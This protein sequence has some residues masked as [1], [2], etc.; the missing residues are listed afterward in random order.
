MSWQIQ[1]GVNI[2][3]TNSLWTVANFYYVIACTNFSLL[4]HAKVES[5]PVMCYQKRR[6]TRFIHPDADAVARHP[7]LRYFKFSTTD[8]VSIAN[9]DFVIGKSIDGEVFSE[10]AEHKIVAPQKALPVMVRIHLVEEYGALLPTVT[11]EISLRIAF[12][13]ESAHH[14]PSIDWRFPDGRSD[15]LAIPCQVARKANVY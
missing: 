4:Q 14:P 10:L 1:E 7:W 5:W 6:H 15:V 11:G 8:A 12:N 13:I 2:S 9:T 3:H